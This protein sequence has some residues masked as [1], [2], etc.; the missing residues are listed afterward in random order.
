MK[1]NVMKKQKQEPKAAKE[2]KVQESAETAVEQLLGVHTDIEAL[3]D[4]LEE[5]IQKLSQAF[6]TKKEPLMKKRDKIIDKIEDFWSTV[7]LSH[8]LFEMSLPDMEKEILQSLRHFQIEKL[9]TGAKLTFTFNQN[10]FFSNTDLVYSYSVNDEEEDA[11]VVTPEIK[12]KPNKNP[13]NKP[14]AK[15]DA[16]GSKR[17]HG[18]T[19][20]DGEDCDDDHSFSFFGWLT[21][22]NSDDA[23]NTQVL[24]LLT[25]DIYTNAVSFY[26]GDLRDDI[27]SDEEG[28]EEDHE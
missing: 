25:G 21:N 16:P 2:K 20:A 13:I 5:E 17:K 9:E 3:E 12:W 8:P 26:A 23:M 11:T 19:H 18:H 7:F 24:E 6:E 1:G 28:S 4:E 10:D 14:L 15:E 22:Q 27:D